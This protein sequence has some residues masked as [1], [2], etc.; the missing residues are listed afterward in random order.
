M[1]RVVH[2]AEPDRRGGHVAQ[3]VP[4]V[5]E[6]GRV[7]VPVQED[8]LLLAQHH[9][10]G[11]D[12]LGHLAQHE[13]PA[14]AGEHTVELEIVADRVVQA[15]RVQHIVHVG[16]V[17]DGADDAKQGQYAVPDDEWR[18]ES[19]PLAALHDPPQRE[20]RDYVENGEHDAVGPVVV[21]PLDAGAC[22]L[23]RV[24]ALLEAEYDR[25]VVVVLCVALVDLFERLHQRA[26]LHKA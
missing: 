25:V 7:V 16:H 5:D 15:V 14:P 4:A 1:D 17:A 24:V 8:E 2:A 10:Q 9:K 3:R 21:D 22:V 23:G 13:L 11:V 26:R 20:Y 18:L 19:E 12:K 6:H